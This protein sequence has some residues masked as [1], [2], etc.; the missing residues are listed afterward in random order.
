[1]LMRLLMREDLIYNIAWAQSTG[2][3]SG[4]EGANMW[5]EKCFR[6]YG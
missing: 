3:I 4:H 5:I 2:T 1:M 6:A